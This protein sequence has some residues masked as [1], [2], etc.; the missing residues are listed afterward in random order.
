MSVVAVWSPFDL[1]LSLAAP[2]GLAVNK[3]T[4][5]V[6]DLDPSGPPLPGDGDLASLVRRGPTEAELVP[7]V[8]GVAVLANGGIAVRDAAEVIGALTARWPHVVM[9]CAPG[10]TPPGGA[11]A[12][13]PVL[14]EPFAIA[15]DRPVVY[16]RT[17]FGGVA[18]PGTATLPIPRVATIR[19]LLSGRIPPL[20]DRWIRSLDEVWSLA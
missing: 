14:P 19:S 1:V 15:L 11:V 7:T 2:L 8:A 5:I 3:G 10:T 4:A 13:V 12:V 18:E 6:V 17:V 9:R 16:Q 20:R